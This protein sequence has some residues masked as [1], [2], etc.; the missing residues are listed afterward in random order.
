MSIGLYV[1]VPFC[2]SKCNY[3]DFYSVGVGENHSTNKMRDHMVAKYLK[4][5]SLEVELIDEMTTREEKTVSSLYIGGG[6]PSCLRTEELEEI[7]KIIN[8]TFT[9]KGHIEVTAEVNPETVAHHKLEQLQKWGVNR[10]SVG[11]QSFDNRQLKQMGRGH[12]EDE[13]E[14]LFSICNKLHINNVSLDLI[15][16]LP[17]QPLEQWKNNLIK[18]VGYKPVHISLYGLKI[19]ETTPWGE[20]LEAGKISFPDDSMQAEMYLKATEVLTAQGYE[21]YEISNFSLPGYQSQHNLNYWLVKPYLGLGPSA[22]SYFKGKRWTN[23]GDLEKYCQQ[24]AKG[25]MP[26]DS[27]EIITRELA[28]AE[29]VFLGLRITAGMEIKR[30]EQEFNVTFEEVYGDIVKSLE[31]KELLK[32][33]SGK[34]F[35][36]QLGRLHGNYVFTEFLL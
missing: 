6:T 11:V 18:A 31:K 36:T 19:E 5:L 1:H 20:L 32:I 4:G 22:S 26:I 15:Y 29:M 34:I 23:F 24:L 35:L 13:I 2:L 27:G 12:A 9:S 16:G 10:L 28:M 21:Q 14:Q 7:F 33:E 8:K 30:F 17:E 3:C 25:I